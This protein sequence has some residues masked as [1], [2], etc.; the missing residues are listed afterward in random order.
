MLTAEAEI[1]DAGAM[2]E[3]ERHF[4]VL[5]PMSQGLG[6]NGVAIWGLR[7]AS[8][9]A[10]R[11]WPVGLVIH[12]E[13]ESHRNAGHEIP[14]GVRVFDARELPDLEAPGAPLH[15]HVRF[16]RKTLG[17]M[18]WSPE[19][20]AIMLPNLDPGTF[21]VAA[22]LASTYGDRLR[23][24]G[25]QH[26]DTAFDSTILTTYEPMLSAM[27]GVSSHITANLRQLATWRAE[28]IAHI[29]SGV[30]CPEEIRDRQS[31]P[32]RLLYAGRFEHQQKRIGILL[33]VARLLQE[34]DVPHTLRLIGD[35]PASLEIAQAVKN[36]PN[37]QCLPP[38]SRRQMVEHNAWADI[39]LLTSRYEG[40]S[41]SMLEAMAAGGV[42]VV[43]RVRSGVMDA[44]DHGVNGLM[45]EAGEHEPDITI[46]ERFGDAI[47]ELADKPER[48]ARMRIAAHKRAKERFSLRA[49][50]DACAQLFR[51]VA[52]AEP[53]WWPLDRPC[54]FGS[55]FGSGSGS[56]PSDAAE[57]A[58]KVLAKEPGPIAIY[59]AGRHTK[60]IADVLAN[61]RVTFV[62]DDDPKL[63]RQTLWGWPIVGLD[64]LQPESTVLISSYMHQQPMA[65]R[66]RAKGLRVVTLY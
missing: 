50:G 46:S 7:L 19:T 5:I 20:P 53:R 16:Y 15:P 4:P 36:L 44:I 58:A 30:E 66:A 6:V 45:I 52:A 21:A 25:W 38:A 37:V 42:P 51:A 18:G 14:E 13:P 59:G 2:S 47:L 35:G 48:L 23:V 63:H 60:A 54:T 33:Q 31:G 27:V 24:V 55:S 17:D 34:A 11:G 56:V 62:V 1:A 41:I 10:S 64:K 40:L 9:L 3:S 28:D 12:A 8:E 65:E 29:P 61:A 22:C 57:R 39:M 26:S 32:I 49:H 43:S